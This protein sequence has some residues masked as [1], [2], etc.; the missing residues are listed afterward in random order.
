MPILRSPRSSTGKKTDPA[1]QDSR[2]ARATDHHAGR[3]AYIPEIDSRRAASFDMPPTPER[4]AVLERVR[5]FTESLKGAIDEGTG[6]ALDRLIEAWT[7]QWI[8]T[9]EDEYTDHCATIAVHRAQAEQWL[10]ESTRIAQHENEEL[11]RL[12]A[13]Y[14]ASRDRLIGEQPGPGHSPTQHTDSNGDLS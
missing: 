12:R 2:P 10:E 5:Q 13:A 3:Y 6:A 1:R 4:G 7:A 8:S 11:G 9:V 14:L